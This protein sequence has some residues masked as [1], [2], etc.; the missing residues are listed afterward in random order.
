MFL[1]LL[2]IKAK[3]LN[4]VGHTGATGNRSNSHTMFLEDEK[5]YKNYKKENIYTT[6]EVEEL[7][8]VKRDL[9]GFQAPSRVVKDESKYDAGFIIPEDRARVEIDLERYRQVK[10]EQELNSII[11]T[12]SYAMI[13]IVT[14]LGLFFLWRNLSKEHKM[15]DANKKKFDKKDLLLKSDILLKDIAS[16][17]EKINEL[18]EKK[19]ITEEEF[20]KLKNRI[21][22]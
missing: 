21:L 13:A 10:K 7:K 8:N 4:I 14:L 3:A 5:E 18:K 2:H 6:E 9:P 17:L 1:H 22:N 19:I 15:S 16:E 11:K 20:L 12:T